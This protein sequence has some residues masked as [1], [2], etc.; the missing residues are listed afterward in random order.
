[1][2]F[3]HDTSHGSQVEPNTGSV[4]INPVRHDVQNDEVPGST[5]VTHGVAHNVHYA[6]DISP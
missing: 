5:H 1:M 6:V 2:Q 4:V 3:K